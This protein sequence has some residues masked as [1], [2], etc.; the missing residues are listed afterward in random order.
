MNNGTNV[1]SLMIQ[2]SRVEEMMHL[3][4][5]SLE[6]NIFCCEWLLFFSPLQNYSNLLHTHGLS[7]AKLT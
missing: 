5:V 1:E 7:F 3:K 6:E 4:T 2:I